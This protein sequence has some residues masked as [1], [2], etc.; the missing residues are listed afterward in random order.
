MTITVELLNEKTLA[1]L[2]DLEQLSLLQ[3]V[4]A[5]SETKP[6]RTKK[7]FSAVNLD[8][9]SFKFNRDEANER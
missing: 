1:L 9:R 2:R 7:V 6:A 4:S 8:T 3:I 5:K